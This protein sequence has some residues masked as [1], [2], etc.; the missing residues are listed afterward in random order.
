V[1]CLKGI[2][3]WTILHGLYRKLQLTLYVLRT[4]VSYE[5]WLIMFYTLACTWFLRDVMGFTLFHHQT[6]PFGLWWPNVFPF[7][8]WRHPILDWCFTFGAWRHPFRVSLMYIFISSLCWMKN[9]GSTPLIFYYWHDMWTNYV[10][11]ASYKKE[12]PIFIFINITLT[13]ETS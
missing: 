7:E 8:A 6:M 13:W 5:L 3:R 9:K 1:W 10:K 11:V 12:N 4:I 2:L